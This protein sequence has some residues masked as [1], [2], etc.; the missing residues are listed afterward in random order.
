MTDDHAI[1]MTDDLDVV[2]RRSPRY[3][4]FMIAGLILGFIVAGVLVMLPV[5]TS[6][7]T[8]DYSMGASMGLLMMLL[9][10]V[11]LGLGGAVALI[12]D[13]TDARRSRT[14]TVRAEYTARGT[15][16]V[17]P[18]AGATTEATS[19][20]SPATASGTATGTDP[21]ADERTIPDV[22]Q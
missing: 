19:E 1:R 11:G 9:G 12:L 22:E 4:T 6:S 2:V 16:A 13:R 14:Y 18:A 8:A 20:A 7:L 17:Q 5:D 3:G 10:M 21:D 15:T